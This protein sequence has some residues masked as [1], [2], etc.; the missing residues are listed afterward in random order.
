[1]PAM[2]RH[3]MAQLAL[4]C[5]IHGMPEPEGVD[6][7][8]SL[9]ANAFVLGDD[10]LGYLRSGRSHN[11]ETMA[12][13]AWAGFVVTGV[14]PKKE[15][16][17]AVALAADLLELNR[18]AFLA[19]EFGS[20]IYSAWTVMGWAAMA[21]ALEG[22]VEKKLAD[23]YRE[24]LTEWI[25]L[26]RLSLARCP[27]EGLNVNVKYQG[28]D[29][30][31]EVL[32]ERRRAGQWVVTICG[33]RSWGHGHG[34]VYFHHDLAR[35]ALGDAPMSA[36]KSSP[37]GRLDKWLE[38][39]TLRLLEVLRK[40][41]RPVIDA[42]AAQDW[43]AFEKMLAY[44]ASAPCELRLYED[45]SRVFVEGTNE[46]EPVD[47]DDNSNTPRMALLAV[48]RTPPRILSLPPWPAPNT[49]ATRIRQKNVWSDID[50]DVHGGGWVLTHSDVGEIPLS[51][52]KWLSKAPDPNSKILARFT[53]F[54]GDGWV[55]TTPAEAAPAKPAPAKPQPATS[56]RGW[57]CARMRRILGLR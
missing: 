27:P 15:R 37:P 23:G 29:G 13:A 32:D 35:I 28:K 30:K 40:A 36:S 49:G 22:L 21:W 25:A 54:S 44:P 5:A 50:R 10:G 57:L 16:D 45:D 6:W 52:G 51:G 9:P 14:A 39:A 3:E 31:V 56:K 48:Y 2:Q 41:A 24:L 12:V 1:M 8:S 46:D 38:R 34:L 20:T 19:N 26:A 47:E 43:A 17:R 55:L 42:W 33:E 11:I 18:R 7:R 53:C 4:D